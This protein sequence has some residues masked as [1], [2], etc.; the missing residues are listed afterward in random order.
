[1]AFFDDGSTKAAEIKVLASAALRGTL[2]QLAPQF[3]RTTG[4][5]VTMDFAPA[6][7][8]KRRIDAGETFTI[9][10]L[11]PTLVDDLI[12]QGKVTADTRAAIG[13][14][15]LGLGVPKGASKPDISSVESLKR[16]LVNAKLV[17]Y[18]AESESGIEFLEVLDRLG[19]SQ[20]MRPKLKAYQVGAAVFGKGE[21]DMF[22]TSTA[23]ILGMSAAE[24]VGSFPP[25]VQIYHDFVA[26][27]SA[28]TDEQEAAR[29]LLQ[30]LV[31]PTATPL[32]KA[33]GLDRF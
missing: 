25:E 10:I 9:V 17:G 6:A 20:E 23:S 22:A 19:L 4:H 28:T 2:V 5:K 21:A 7:V 12:K 27:I 30:F 11:S 33:K 18:T 32:L 24:L 16:T 13:R 14:V 29:A 15:G 26:G 3:E 31:S 1:V 8:L